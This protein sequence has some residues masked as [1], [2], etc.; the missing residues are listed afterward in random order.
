[1]NPAGSLAVDSPTQLAAV[2]EL[3]EQGRHHEAVEALRLLARSGE[4]AAMYLLG[5]RLLIGRNAPLAP[6][7]GIV[8]LTDAAQRDNPEATAQLATLNAAGSWMPQNWPVALD[9]LQQAAAL[10]SARARG[11]LLLLAEDRTLA[12]RVGGG[13][14]PPGCWQA[15]AQS[16]NVDNWRRPL[17]RQS[18]CEAPRIRYVENLVAAEICDW[19]ID[20]AR[21]RLKV[22]RMFD[23][24]RPVFT[25]TRNNSD[26]CFDIVEADLVVIL[27]RERVSSV[28]KLP[29]FAMEPPQIFHYALGQEIKNH[30]DHVSSEGG[31]PAERI[32]TL[33]LYLNDDY[34]GGE[35]D[36]PKVGFRRKGCKGDAIYFANVDAAGVPDKL[37]LHAALP[38]TRGE[39]WMLSQWVQDRTF[40]S[41]S[42]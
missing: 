41:A 5:T 28:V 34:D 25:A 6:Q 7:E 16:I 1:M 9:L 4:A 18:L 35:L 14:Q 39:K 33:L 3:D 40:G 17:P 10:G 8:L 24:H 19:L 20:R 23:G 30:Y 38:V 37:S 11:Q 13:M 2:R 36:F 15:L 26:Y 32:A 31:Y 29:V 21:G 22:A 27:L 12:Q 42:A